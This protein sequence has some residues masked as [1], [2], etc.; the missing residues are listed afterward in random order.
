VEN[1]ATDRTGHKVNSISKKR[2]NLYGK[3]FTTSKIFDNFVASNNI[4]KIKKDGSKRSK[5]K[6]S[7]TVYHRESDIRYGV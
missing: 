7:K 2:I 1:K 3:F 4:T 6:I 5:Q